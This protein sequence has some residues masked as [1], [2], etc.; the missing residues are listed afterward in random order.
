MSPDTKQALHLALVLLLLAN[1]I[2]G[3]VTHSRLPVRRTET[4]VAEFLSILTIVMA[5]FALGL[6]GK[7][8]YEN[9]RRG[10]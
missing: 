9:A 8:F 10:L 5:L 2:L 1:G 4:S 3:L 6:F 7:Q